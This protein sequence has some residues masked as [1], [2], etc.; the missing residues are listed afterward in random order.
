MEGRDFTDILVKDLCI[1]YKVIVWMQ[2][3]ANMVRDYVR[4]EDRMFLR[5]HNI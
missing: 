3:R 5:R 4:N 2:I 1:I